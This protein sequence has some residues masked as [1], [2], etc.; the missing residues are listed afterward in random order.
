M[1]NRL[2]SETV[3]DRLTLLHCINY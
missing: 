3:R 2:V 1:E